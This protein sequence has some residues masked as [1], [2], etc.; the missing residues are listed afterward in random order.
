LKTT[1]IVDKNL[2]ESFL[3]EHNE[4]TPKVP[5]DVQD[6]QSLATTEIPIDKHSKKVF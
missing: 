4:G 3:R 6:L 2:V 1:T 5:E